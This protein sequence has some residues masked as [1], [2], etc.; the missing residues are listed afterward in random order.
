[1]TLEDQAKWHEEQAAT[2]DENIVACREWIATAENPIDSQD[3]A[4]CLQEATML[5]AR[6]RASAAGCREL[7]DKKKAFEIANR[8]KHDEMKWDTY[9]ASLNT[10]LE[11]N[12]VNALS[13]IP[14]A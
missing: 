2:Y 3:A 12:T 4:S 9:A 8:E 6:H 10:V 1:M 5:A 7:A 11:A 14:H 13:E